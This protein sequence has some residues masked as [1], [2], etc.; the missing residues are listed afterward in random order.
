M[1]LVLQ[2]ACHHIKTGYGVSQP[3]CRNEGFNNPIAGIGKGNGLGPSL[4][5]LISTIIIKCCK[6]KGHWTTIT[7]PI[8]KRIVSFLGFA[9]VD[10]TDLVTAANDS[11]QSGGEMVQK[12]QALMTDWCGCIRATD[13]L[14]A[15]TKTRR[16]L[17]SFFWNGNAWNYLTKDSLPRD[18]SLHDKDG[19]LYTVNR[20]EATSPFWIFGPTNG[21]CQHL[22]CSAW[23]YYFWIPNYFN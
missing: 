5:C 23:W 7:T 14:I 8:S 10:D 17:V 9:F 11:Y 12:M 21:H 3:A 6:R 4:W 13:V 20:E 1:F 19:N 16:F 22:I 15:P 18:I 2:Q